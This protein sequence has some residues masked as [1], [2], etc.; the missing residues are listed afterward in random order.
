MDADKLVIIDTLRTFQPGTKAPA[1]GAIAW[2]SQ[3]EA[4]GAEGLVSVDGRAVAAVR[5]GRAALRVER[6]K[7]TTL[8]EAVLSRA[9]GRPGSWR[10]EFAGEPAFKRGS[11]QV[12][13]GK[14][15]LV[16]PDAVVFAVD[17]KAGERVAFTFETVD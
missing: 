6:R 15:T 7:G 1:G 2:S 9:S 16:A 8:V 14:A 5:T 13:A 11:L 4:A 17:G 12:H 3:L 10:F